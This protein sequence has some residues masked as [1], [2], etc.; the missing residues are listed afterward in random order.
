MK[1]EATGVET[2]AVTRGLLKTYDTTEPIEESVFRK[3]LESNGFDA[4]ELSLSI[5]S[6]GI[7][8]ASRFYR[9]LHIIQALTPPEKLLKLFSDIS[10]KST[11]LLKIL[12]QNSSSGLEV[13]IFLRLGG[14]R[15]DK[16]VEMISLLGTAAHKARAKICDCKYD[17]LT[18]FEGEKG[19][20]FDPIPTSWELTSEEKTV[21]ME[22]VFSVML[23]A[24]LKSSSGRKEAPETRLYIVLRELFLDLGGTRQI[25]S[26]TEL[27]KFVTACVKL[28]NEEIVMPEPE[29]FRILMMQALP[30]HAGRSWVIDCR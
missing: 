30:R 29:P 3:I 8:L 6:E 26:G 15:I 2:Y 7:Q 21:L 11:Q 28:I 19:P 23:A 14:V 17:S 4:N 13:A 18:M 10:T 24:P 5:L 27:Y 22:L 12:D 1:T 16:A 25:G 20:D 9:I